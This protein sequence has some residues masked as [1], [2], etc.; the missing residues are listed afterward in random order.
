MWR[1]GSIGRRLAAPLLRSTPPAEPVRVV[2]D[3]NQSSPRFHGV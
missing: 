3:L 1:L 2:E